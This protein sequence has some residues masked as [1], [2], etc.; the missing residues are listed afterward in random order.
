MT[1]P[2]GCTTQQLFR[3]PDAAR[4][5]SISRT[6]LYREIS[7]GRITPVRIGKAVRISSDEIQA[8]ARRLAAEAGLAT[9][10]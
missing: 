8:Y 5:L 1:R 7:E 4:A 6:T 10:A 9:V 2:C 3:F